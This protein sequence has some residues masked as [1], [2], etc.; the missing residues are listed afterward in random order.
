MTLHPLD[1]EWLTFLAIINPHYI[2]Y[3]V[4]V[5]ANNPLIDTVRDFI[6]LG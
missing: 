6:Y 4:E 2:G 5:E 1:D 3:T